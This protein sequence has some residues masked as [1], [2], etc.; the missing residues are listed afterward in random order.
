MNGWFWA[1]ALC[2]TDMKRV[3]LAAALTL[4]ASSL[5][6]RDLVSTTTLN[7][8]M[9]V[10]VIEDHR[11]PVVVHMLWVK[12][13][14]AD[15]PAGKAG[16]AHFL[17]HLMFKATD[18]LESG[19]FSRVVAAQGGSDNAF[20]SYDYTAYFQRVAADRLG[21]MMQMESDRMRNL[22]LTEEEVATERR[23]ILEE[24]NQRIENNPGALAREQF[25]AAQYLSHPYGDPVI[26]W[27]HEMEALTQQDAR[28][29]YDLFYAPNNTV[30]VVAGDVT[31][32]EVFALAQQYYGP[33]LPAD[34]LAA[35][36]RPQE[37]PQRAERRL[38][39][40]DPRVAQPYLR[41][42]YLAPSRQHEDQRQ[43]AALTYLAEILG[44][45]P[46]TSV[47]ARALQFDDQIAVFA[48]AGYGGEALDDTTFTLSVAPAQG[49]T[50]EDAEAAMDRV[51]DQFLQ[52]G[53]DPAQVE[54]LRARFRADDVYARDNTQSV[55]ER[56]GRALTQ[57]LTIED[58]QNWP[59][60]LQD[61]TAEDIHQAARDL[62]DRRNAVTGYVS[63]DGGDQG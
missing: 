16:V 34:G 20:T 43:A 60:V 8:G 50:L 53:P 41:R 27:M 10:V 3:L 28:D 31:P 44:G 22:R 18:T 6:A 2:C 61:V 13:G 39:Y 52:D 12:A 45:S 19:E 29:Y 1:P 15:E 36:E 14:S 48:G 47:L 33:I 23:V 26:G 7:N 56:Y 55:A 21:L 62:F 11:A 49:V 32:D 35:R 57:G 38:H 54:A 42:S 59:E 58:V 51:L 9:Q 17:E 25:M 5:F 40:T 4:V 37:P 30:L 24:R 63:R 46:F